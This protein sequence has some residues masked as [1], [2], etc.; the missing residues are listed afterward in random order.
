MLGI[1]NIH[2][3]NIHITHIYKELIYLKRD[4]LVATRGTF[5]RGLELSGE[6]VDHGTV[7]R[8]QV[9]L[10]EL[11]SQRV[12]LERFVHV[13]HGPGLDLHPVNVHVQSVKQQSQE[14]LGI[15]LLVAGK[16]RGQPLECRL[17]RCGVH[18][19]AVSGGPDSG[20]EVSVYPDQLAV[21]PIHVVQYAVRQAL[22]VA[23]ALQH[24]V[25]I[26]RVSYVPDTDHPLFRIGHRP[27]RRR[28]RLRMQRSVV[29]DSAVIC[30][31]HVDISGWL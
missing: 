28:R 26:A 6:Q 25:H 11:G 30:P 8:G 14:L 1:P 7:V 29:Y 2:R 9:P 18:R 5:K 4:T 19:M 27:V 12:V 21:G 23:Q 15:L 22:G 13:R 20:Q 24:R 16:P 10:P 3:T 31:V 17:E